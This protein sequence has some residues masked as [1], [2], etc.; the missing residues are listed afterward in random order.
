MVFPERD[1]VII[2]QRAIQV[3]SP[4][5]LLSTFWAAASAPQPARPCDC[6]V[7]G[8]VPRPGAGA[9]G[10]LLPLGLQMLHEE[11]G[12]QAVITTG[13]GQH[14]MWAAQWYDYDMPRCWATSGERRRSPCTVHRSMAGQACSAQKCG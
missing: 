5:R 4:G 7:W 8:R 13:V 2:P 14:Q 9:E 6:A 12:G 1:D 10:V 11:T 3:G